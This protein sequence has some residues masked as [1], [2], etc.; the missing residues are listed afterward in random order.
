MYFGNFAL[1]VTKC[2]HHNSLFKLLLSHKTVIFKVFFV[3]AGR[4]CGVTDTNKNQDRRLIILS[5]R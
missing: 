4:S 1:N 5:V 2:Y 3:L